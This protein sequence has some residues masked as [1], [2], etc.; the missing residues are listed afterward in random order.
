MGD[1]NEAGR[2]LLAIRVVRQHSPGL[3]AGD[4]FAG[5]GVALGRSNTIDCRAKHTIVLRVGAAGA[6]E[7]HVATLDPNV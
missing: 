3:L 5:A 4:D 2:D 7:G 6:D 1:A